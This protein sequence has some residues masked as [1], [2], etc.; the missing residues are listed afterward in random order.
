MSNTTESPEVFGQLTP[1]EVQQISA[2]KKSFE[3]VLRTLGELK[4][5]EAQLVK[6]GTML[7]EAAAELLKTIAVRIGVGHDLS[8]YAIRQDGSV[9]KV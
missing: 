4:M 9:I 1:E 6:Q 7:D 2:F 5:R 3:E 8:G